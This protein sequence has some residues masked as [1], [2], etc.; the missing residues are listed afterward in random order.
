MKHRK[1]LSK[2]YFRI[3]IVWKAMIVVIMAACVITGVNIKVASAGFPDKP[4]TVIV[5][6]RA[7]GSTDTMIR[8]YAK[9]LAKELGQPVIVQNRPGA[10]GN[11]GA[12]YIKNQPADGYTFLVGSVGIP[13]WSP[14]HDQVEF[15][16]EDF[17][18]LGAITEYQQAL[19]STPKKPFK[20]LSELIAYSKKNPGE[21]VFADQGSLEK[22]VL[23]WVGKQEGVEWRSVPTKGG[24]GMVPMLLGGQID[25]AYSGGVHQ[26]Y[27]DKMTVLASLNPGR[28]AASPDVPSISEKYDISIPSLVIVIGPKD[29][30]ADRAKILENALKKACQDK[31]FVTLLT[32]NLKFPRL[33][34]TGKEVKQQVPVLIEQLK[35]AKKIMNQ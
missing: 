30:P 25:F 23:S 21:V 7:G 13:V 26:R 1:D 3:K 11:V 27:G 29:I 16:W 14:I 8:V 12:T 28:L 4:L 19:I 2:P 15:T 22:L 17:T 34:K 18:Y 24:G 9:A 35:N 31:K 5:P 6:Y 20:T 32:E 10:S 33:F